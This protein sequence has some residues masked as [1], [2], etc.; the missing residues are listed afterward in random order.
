MHQVQSRETIR[1]IA[2]AYGVSAS[3]IIELNQ[4]GDPPQLHSGPLL[5]PD[6]KDEA[7]AGG[8]TCSPQFPSPYSLDPVVTVP[9][10]TAFPF[11]LTS[12]GI[13]ARPNFANA[14]GCDWMG[15]GG[16]AFARNA[17]P[18]AGLVVH[19]EGSGLSRDVLTGSK[20]EY[21]PGGYEI[22]LEDHLATTTGVYRVQLRDAHGEPLSNWIPVYTFADCSRNLL[23]VNFA[24]K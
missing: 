12:E 14:A 16:Q 1:C 3:A 21:G 20:S 8:R 6:V 13:T 18:L 10:P 19:L 5:I 11:V 7:G 23:M 15:I 17:E 9:A 2:S 4:L 22:Q 24:Q